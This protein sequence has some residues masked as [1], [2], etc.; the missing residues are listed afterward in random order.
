MGLD[1]AISNGQKLGICSWWKRT[2][3]QVVNTLSGP[4]KNREDIVAAR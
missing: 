4:P 1:K 3:I 2:K